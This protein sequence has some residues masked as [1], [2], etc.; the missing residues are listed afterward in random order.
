MK[1]LNKKISNW[2]K[3]NKLLKIKIYISFVLIIPYFRIQTCKNIN[4]CMKRI[5]YADVYYSSF[6]TG[7][8]GGKEKENKS[9]NYLNVLQ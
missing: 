2:K 6:D 3:Q 4:I 9:E 1:V 5:M 8:D 7:R